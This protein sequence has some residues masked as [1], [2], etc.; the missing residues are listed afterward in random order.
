MPCP[1]LMSMRCILL[2]LLNDIPAIHDCHDAAILEKA[3]DCY[4]PEIIQGWVSGQSPDL[5]EKDRLRLRDPNFVCFVYEE[6]D[7]IYG[8][9]MIDYNKNY[10][11]AIYVRQGA[12][13]KKVGQKLID[14]VKLNA[15][16]RG[17]SE[18][19]FEASLNSQEFYER[20][21]AETIEISTHIMGAG[22]KMPCVKM[23]LKIR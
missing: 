20:N 6:K 4:L 17:A 1:S 15:L 8:F 21:G 14:Y 10:L 22:Q 11:N 23:R 19:S 18:L 7:T 12:R 9:A 3:S 2:I 13:E 5:I 16:E